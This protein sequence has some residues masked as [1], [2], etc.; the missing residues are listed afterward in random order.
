MV[1]KNISDFATHDMKLSYL[2]FVL[3]LIVFLG[4]MRG[5][6]K[7][8]G[9]A[10]TQRTTGSN[11]GLPTTDWSYWVVMLAA[12]VLGT[13]LGDWLADTGPGGYWAALIRMPFF[14]RAGWG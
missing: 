11:A 7:F 4:A 2:V 9:D 12:G 1:A 10:T 6:D 5:A 14:V 13:A 8:M 3:L